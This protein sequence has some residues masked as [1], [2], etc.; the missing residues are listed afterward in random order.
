[1]SNRIADERGMVVWDQGFTLG[2]IFERGSDRGSK[3]PSESRNLLEMLGRQLVQGRIYE[4]KGRGFESRRAHQE[5]D[6]ERSLSF[7]CISTLPAFFN[8]EASK[9]PD[10]QIRHV[11]DMIARN[12]TRFYVPKQFKNGSKTVQKKSAGNGFK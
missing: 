8:I 11:R 4:S 5:G 9:V 12:F 7:L 3:W 1:M 10:Y 2:F 6:F